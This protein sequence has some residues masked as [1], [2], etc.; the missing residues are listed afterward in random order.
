MKPEH[1]D[2]VRLICPACRRVNT[3]KVLHLHDPG[4]SECGNPSCRRSLR[5]ELD[6]LMEAQRRILN[7]ERVALAFIMLLFLA[8]LYIVVR[9]L[10]GEF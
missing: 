5:P 2:V 4:D 9:K 8:V 1:V 6:G 3:F 7:N 10:F